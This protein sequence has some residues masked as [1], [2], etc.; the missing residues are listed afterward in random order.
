MELNILPQPWAVSENEGDLVFQAEAARSFSWN[1]PKMY[2]G[3]IGRRDAELGIL[4]SAPSLKLKRFRNAL[5]L[6][7]SIVIDPIESK[8]LVGSYFRN[9]MY[10]FH[11]GV[12]RLPKA[13]LKTKIPFNGDYETTNK[14]V[15]SLDTDWPHGFGHLLLD[16]LPRL[17]ALRYAPYDALLVNSYAHQEILK[18]FMIALEIDI[19]RL[20]YLNKPLFTHDFYSADA[21]IDRKESV[22]PEFWELISKIKKFALK[23]SSL[24]SREFPKKI[25][26]SRK[27]FNTHTLLNEDVVE[28]YFIRLGF[29]SI[30]PEKLD[31]WDQIALYSQVEQMVGPGGTGMHMALFAPD[32]TKVLILS[33]PNWFFNADTILAQGFKD[34]LCHVVGY[35]DGF[36]FRNEKPWTIKLED[37]EKAVSQ[38]FI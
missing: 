31:I 23:F 37:V 29:V 34:R 28:D 30:A 22:H 26:I 27:N 2:G 9:N 16:G 25:Y 10:N 7:R 38:H 21:S 33:P 36:N 3:P 13:M 12:H 8:V 35:Q 20:K 14:P 18:F 1:M 11:G 19:N 4:H 5:V 6:P 17:W 32:D 15:Y 24:K